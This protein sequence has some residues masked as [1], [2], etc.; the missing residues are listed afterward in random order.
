[1]T[2]RIPSPARRRLLRG[3]AALCCIPALRAETYPSRPLRLV[4]PN[5]PGSAVDTLARQLMRIMAP[6]LGQPVVIENVPGSGGLLGM[7]QLLRNPRDGYTFG[8]VASNFAIAPN[9]YKLPYDSA[10]DID[11]I[12]VLV[13]G[14]MVLA[15]NSAVPATN[16]KELI[17]LAKSRPPNRALTYASA[18]VGTLGHL[19]AELLAVSAGMR[20]LHVPYK[21]QNGFTTDLVSGVVECGFAT[22][23]VFAPFFASGKLRAIAVSTQQ[24]SASLPNV[25]TLAESGLPDFNLGGWQML[26]AAHGTPRA[27]IE[28]LNAAARAALR[29]PEM[30]KEAAEGGHQIVAS[31]VPEATAWSKRELDQ[32]ARLS[33]KIG[34]KPE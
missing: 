20:M 32:F 1:M 16:L 17:A 27:R 23:A 19:A 25:P 6:D 33:Q 2:Q 34:I 31:T 29:S 10:K 8:M 21:G 22:P 9:L 12:C 18:G 4:L 30:L 11:P 28:R 5:A 24:R 3:A 7:Q 14:A 26:I 13:N 15:V